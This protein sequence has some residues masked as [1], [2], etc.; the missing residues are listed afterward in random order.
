MNIIIATYGN[1]LIYNLKENNIKSFECPGDYFETLVINNKVITICKPEYKKYSDNYL[2]IFDSKNSMIKIKG[3]NISSMIKSLDDKFFYYTCSDSNMLFK[4]NT[5]SLKV[6]KEIQLCNDKKKISSLALKN[7]IIYVAIESNEVSSVSL[8]DMNNNHNKIKSYKRLGYSI[9]NLVFWEDG[10]LYLNPDLGQLCYF[11]EKTYQNL[12]L[13]SFNFIKNNKVFIRGLFVINKFAFVGVNY[14]GYR[15]N[16]SASLACVNLITNRLRWLRDLPIKSY[17]NSLTFSGG[18]KYITNKVKNI[19]I[20]FPGLFT[21][22]KTDTIRKLG[23][24]PIIGFKNTFIP[25][26]SHKHI[27]KFIYTNNDCSK[28]YQTEYFKKYQ[29]YIRAIIR[30]IF[31]T[32]KLGNIAKCN[33]ILYKKGYNQ[34]QLININ[35][36]HR[37]IILAI[38]SNK[39]MLFNFF[40]KNKWESHTIDEGCIVELNN[41]IRHNIINKGPTEGIFFIIDYSDKIIND[42]IL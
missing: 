22:E 18:Y 7:N 3:N 38:Q 42:K 9:R 37:R 5:I 17:I 6:E 27:I 1:I 15:G 41:T 33:L 10:F 21:Y 16:Q 32:K 8:F 23:Y 31:G 2:K 36:N 34:E 30:Y 19:I 26:F 40:Y 4:Y 13:F 11:N 39:N 12:I 25:N 29:K 24:Y 14:L 35:N 28:Y 20:K